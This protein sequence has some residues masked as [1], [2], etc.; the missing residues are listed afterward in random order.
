MPIK[1]FIP[2]PDEYEDVPE[3]ETRDEAATDDTPSA[4]DTRDMARRRNTKKFQEQQVTEFWQRILGDPI[5]RRVMWGI[6]DGFHAF[7]T[8]FACTPAGFSSPESTWFHAGQQDCGLRLYHT[9]MRFDLEGTNRMLQEYHPD[10][11]KSK[12]KRKSDG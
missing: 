8:K 2:P 10:F 3:I 9:F 6:L 12:G 7:E 4:T 1:P 5:G 11:V